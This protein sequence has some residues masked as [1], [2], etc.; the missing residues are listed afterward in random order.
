MLA[1]SYLSRT[2]RAS[3]MDMASS[4]ERGKAASLARSTPSPPGPVK[5][6]SALN[7]NPEP[8]GLLSA[9]FCAARMALGSVGR[10]SCACAYAENTVSAPA[11]ASTRPAARSKDFTLGKMV[12][13]ALLDCH[14]RGR[15]AKSLPPNLVLGV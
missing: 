13:T 11:A 10:A 4:S 1:R 8:V 3:P 9:S 2:L 7:T 15:D 5:L 6:P 14:V 12:V